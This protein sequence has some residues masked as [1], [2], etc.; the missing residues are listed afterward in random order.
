MRR[1]KPKGCGYVPGCGHLPGVGEKY[2]KYQVTNN[3]I[4][5]SLPAKPE[6]HLVPTRSLFFYLLRIGNLN[7]LTIISR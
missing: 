2:S 4:L 6:I 7:K 5:K 3:F 1:K